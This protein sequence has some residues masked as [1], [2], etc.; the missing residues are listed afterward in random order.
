MP[1]AHKSART[2]I[3]S[4]LKLEEIIKQKFYAHYDYGSVEEEQLSYLSYA[5][6]NSE[7]SNS[8]SKGF[9]FP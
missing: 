8:G 4:I 9:I 7:K 6:K 3:I 1:S 2:A 5:P